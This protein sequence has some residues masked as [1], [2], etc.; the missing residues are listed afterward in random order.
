MNTTRITDINSISDQKSK[1]KLSKDPEGLNKLSEG[2]N[3]VQHFPLV[4]SFLRIA[5]FGSV[6]WWGSMMLL[7][8][9]LYDAVR[10][11]H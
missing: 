8:F 5:R 9:Q 7:L 6:C 3:P 11:K 10:S 1:V 2:F 4:Q